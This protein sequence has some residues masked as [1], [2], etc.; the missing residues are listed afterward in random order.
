MRLAVKLL[1][2][3]CCA[4]EATG[5]PV[6]KYVGNEGGGAWTSDNC[7]FCICILISQKLCIYLDVFNLRQCKSKITVSGASKLGPPT[8]CCRESKTAVAEPNAKSMLGGGSCLQ[9]DLNQ[10]HFSFLA[11]LGVCQ[12]LA[13]LPG[14]ATPGTAATHLCRRAR[15]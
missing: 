3:M 14:A 9:G 2:W 15:S 11:N 12:T 8:P 1:M 5:I 7:F 13:S 4:G 10:I 6:G